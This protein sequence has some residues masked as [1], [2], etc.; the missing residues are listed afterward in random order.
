MWQTDTESICQGRTKQAARV[1][2]RMVLTGL[3]TISTYTERGRELY[4]S[5]LLTNA[6][7]GVYNGYSI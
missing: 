6:P 1:A 3:A 7:A 4:F 2:S 5:S